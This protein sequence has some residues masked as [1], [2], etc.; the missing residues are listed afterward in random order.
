[1]SNALLKVSH[2]NV[3]FSGNPIL[4]N[5]SFEVQKGETLA[6]I[7][8]N[9]AGKTVLF[10]TLLGLVPYSGQITWKPKI[11]IGYVPQ[12]LYVESDLPLTTAEFFHLKNI[13]NPEIHRVM[14]AVGFTDPHEILNSKL[15]ILSGGQ[16]QRVLIAWA[17]AGHPEILLFD[18]PTTG[19]DL[20]AEESI[21]S[22]LKKLQD[23]ET[24]TLL[25]ISH[26]LQVVYRY[27]TNVLCLNKEGLCYGP[28]HKALTQEALSQLFGEHTSIYHHQ[29]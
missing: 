14:G 26:E 13:S 16:L 28:P 6:I 17:L 2:L 15:G 25:L 18:E 11:K 23:Q 24:L 4:E 21:Y 12:R 7:G 10:R 29:H 5:L 20:S 22:L 27:A 8:P 3:S 9:G 1:M 19:V